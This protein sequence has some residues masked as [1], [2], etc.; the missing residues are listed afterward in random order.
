VFEEFCEHHDAGVPFVSLEH[1]VRAE[2]HV[3]FDQLSDVDAWVM[4][5]YLPD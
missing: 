5:K 3:F 1:I 4:G 2:V